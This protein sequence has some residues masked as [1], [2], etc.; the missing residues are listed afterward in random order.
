MQNTA[1]SLLHL[2]YPNCG[3]TSATQPINE[4]FSLSTFSQWFSLFNYHY[5]L[6]HCHTFPDTDLNYFCSIVSRCVPL[7]SPILYMVSSMVGNTPASSQISSRMIHLKNEGPK[8]LR[9]YAT[10]MQ[11]PYFISVYYPICISCMT[12]FQSCCLIRVSGMLQHYQNGYGAMQ[13]KH[14]NLKFR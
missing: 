5:L 6:K 9:F 7:S 3:H 1:V 4:S 2:S 8:S 14:G 12:I 10:T 11:C 13:N